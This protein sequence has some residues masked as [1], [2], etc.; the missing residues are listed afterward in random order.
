M[1]TD[2]LDPDMG[3]LNPA[4]ILLPKTWDVDEDNLDNQDPADV[5]AKVRYV[6]E[7]WQNAFDETLEWRSA[8]LDTKEKVMAAVETIKGVWEKV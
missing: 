1:F 7:S 6:L 8:S 5:A 4:A 3:G 2:I